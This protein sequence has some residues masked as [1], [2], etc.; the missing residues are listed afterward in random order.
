MGIDAIIG[1]DA[2]ASAPSIVSPEIAISAAQHRQYTYATNRNNLSQVE[3]EIGSLTMH[4]LD[5]IKDLNGSG[6]FTASI[7]QDSLHI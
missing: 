5:C 2:S 6:L 3:G 4:A 1:K 7:I